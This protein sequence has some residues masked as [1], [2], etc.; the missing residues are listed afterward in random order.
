M[1][2]LMWCRGRS[3]ISHGENRRGRPFGFEASVTHI[4]VYVQGWRLFRLCSRNFR[5]LGR[6]VCVGS[7]V[8][9]G[10]GTEF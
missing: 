8:R 3:S 7:N 10:A 6:Q 5:F 9:R 4:G 2:L 1:K